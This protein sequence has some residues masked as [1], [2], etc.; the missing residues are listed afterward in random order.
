M[1]YVFTNEPLYSICSKLSFEHP[2]DAYLNQNIKGN[3]CQLDVSKIIIKILPKE[4]IRIIS[5]KWAYSEISKVLF[6]YE[7]KYNNKGPRKIFEDNHKSKLDEINNLIDNT[8]GY[9]CWVLRAISY[10]LSENFLHSV[11]SACSVSAAYDSI[12][13][14]KD[15][16]YQKKLDQS[17][18]NLLNLINNI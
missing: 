7:K 16:D 8:S 2:Y 18:E 14:V 11:Q 13:Y 9:E 4:F 15:I 3:L 17:K 12:G 6:I 10:Y 5:L 1:T